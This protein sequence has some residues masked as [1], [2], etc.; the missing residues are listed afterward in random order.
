MSPAHQECLL[1]YW[2]LSRLDSWVLPQQ[3][4]TS[5]ISTLATAWDPSSTSQ[6][7]SCAVHLPSPSLW[8]TCHDL[9]TLC[10]ALWNP[11]CLAA[12][13]LLT[14]LSTSMA[15]SNELWSLFHISKTSSTSKSRTWYNQRGLS[16]LLVESQLDNLIIIVLPRHSKSSEQCQ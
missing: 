3:A 8:L 6:A 5:A 4:S 7:S 15:N 16:A 12:I 14:W 2:P 1:H 9:S 11:R 10:A 13:N